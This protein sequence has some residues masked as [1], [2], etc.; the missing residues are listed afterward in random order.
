MCVGLLYL[1]T[2]FWGSHHNWLVPLTKST[3]ILRSASKVQK[4]AWVCPET[5]TLKFL[6]CPQNL[7]PYLDP[8]PQT[9][10]H[11]R[12]SC[13]CVGAGLAVVHESRPNIYLSPSWK[14]VCSEC[15]AD[16]VL[17]LPAF[18]LIYC[19]SPLLNFINLLQRGG[20]RLYM[21]KVSESFIPWF[22]LYSIR[23][24][25]KVSC[26]ITIL[27]LFYLISQ[28][29]ESL[30]IRWARA[31]CQWSRAHTPLGQSLSNFNRVREW[32][33]AW[34]SYLT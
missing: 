13:A 12:K 20:S 18:N 28:G 7:T 11:T 25:I 6:V 31:P 10:T 21:R 16:T 24:F 23:S 34:F 19:L 9:H 17:A 30:L 1:H 22:Y 33:E 8:P 32:K 29:S 3:K 15:V 26:A 5:H 27:T 14:G 2:C 4:K